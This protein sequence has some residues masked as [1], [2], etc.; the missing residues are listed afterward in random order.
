MQAKDMFIVD[1]VGKK[2]AIFYVP[3]YQR[4]Y[5]W[6]ENKQVKQLWEDLNEFMEMDLDDFFLGSL[7]I[8]KIMVWIQHTF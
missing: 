3:L 7:I 8:K 4:K 5:T 1:L 6:E 2:D